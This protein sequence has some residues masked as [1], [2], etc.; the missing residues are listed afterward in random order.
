MTQMERIHK[1]S[2]FIDTKSKRILR[3]GFEEGLSELMFWSEKGAKCSG[4]KYEGWTLNTL[5]NCSTR[6]NNNCDRSLTDDIAESLNTLGC[7]DD[8]EEIVIQYRTCLS[9]EGDDM[10][11]CFQLINQL[12]KPNCDRDIMDS[13][14]YQ[15]WE[16]HKSCIDTVVR[17]NQAFKRAAGEVGY[18]ARDSDD[19]KTA[20]WT[21][22]HDALNDDGEA[23]DAV[24]AR[25]AGLCS[26]NF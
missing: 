9:R 2:F 18:C 3:H 21:R 16:A 6:V 7:Y 25:W 12:P 13:W 17:C 1:W 8:A 5:K 22:N 24:D 15:V 19:E 10:C 4:G 26:L 23:D 20:P 14:Q 11:Q